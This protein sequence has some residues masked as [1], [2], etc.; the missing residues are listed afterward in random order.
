MVK[1]FETLYNESQ[2]LTQVFFCRIVKTHVGVKTGVFVTT[3]PGLVPVLRVGLDPCAKSY[4]RKA[5]TDLP[6][7]TNASAKTEEAAT[8]SRESANVPPDGR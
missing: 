8:P 4:V 2:L 6:A 1:S 5:P 3:Y 7:V